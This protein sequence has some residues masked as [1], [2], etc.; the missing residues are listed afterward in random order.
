MYNKHGAAS[1]IS[2]ATKLISLR[3]GNLAVE[4][5][6]KIEGYEMDTYTDKGIKI[7]IPLLDKFDSLRI[8]RISYVEAGQL[9]TVECI[10]DDKIPEGDTFDYTDV[11]EAALSVHTLEEYNSMT[12]IHIIP[13]VIESKDD[14]MFAANI[15]D[16][17]EADD[18]RVLDWNA[19]EHVTYVFVT[20]DIVGDV[21]DDPGKI[22]I[23][24]AQSSFSKTVEVTEVG[25]ERR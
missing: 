25:G 14:Y 2:T 6:N 19:D 3:K 5:S 7:T 18:Q 9:P 20:A 15:K 24:N 22:T 21:N 13:E 23:K 12:G 4:D 10:Y 17:T 11:G 1:E 8:Y 16:D